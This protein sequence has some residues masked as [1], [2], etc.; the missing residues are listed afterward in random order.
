M[1]EEKAKVV[2]N[3][4]DDVFLARPL[5]RDYDSSFQIGNFIFDL[6][7]NN[8]VQGIELINA[9]KMF[10]VPKAFL[11]DMISGKIEIVVSERYIQIN[12]QIKTKV[13]NADNTSSLSI[14]RV[15][16][17]FINPTEL[18]LAIA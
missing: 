15:K 4:E 18:H 6:D 17:E 16:P 10:G 11:K 7:Q 9:S 14:E 2:Y 12:I 1:K 5:E 13:R 8:K 3:F